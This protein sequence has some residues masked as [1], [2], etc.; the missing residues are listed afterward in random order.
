MASKDSQSTNTTRPRSS[1]SSDPVKDSDAKDKEITE[2]R[3]TLKGLSTSPQH[4]SAVGE[5][6]PS[7]LS[8]GAAVQRKRA[9]SL[10]MEGRI[11]HLGEQDFVPEHLVSPILLQGRQKLKGQLQR[12]VH[13]DLVDMGVVTA[14]KHPSLVQRRQSDPGKINPALMQARQKY[15]GSARSSTEEDLKP[16]PRSQSPRR[17]IGSLPEGKSLPSSYLQVEGRLSPSLTSPRR[18]L[19]QHRHSTCVN[20]LPATATAGDETS[21]MRPRTVRSNSLPVAALWPDR[22]ALEV[23]EAVGALAVPNKQVDKKRTLQPV[24]LNTPRSQMPSM[25]RPLTSRCMSV[26]EGPLESILEESGTRSQFLRQYSVPHGS[27]PPI[28]GV[29]L[30]PLK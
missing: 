17:L 30:K 24:N 10:Q 13:D 23:G 11:P 9:V 27:S 1:A 3:N 4:K 21:R 2:L 29:K 15:I 22:S 6:Q 28:A 8:P 26:D 7:S 20:Y 18:K 12:V 19:L 25:K 16:R 5:A 14:A